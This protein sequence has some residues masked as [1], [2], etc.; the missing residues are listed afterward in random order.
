M[1]CKIELATEGSKLVM[2]G[3]RGKLDTLILWEL[4]KEKLLQDIDKVKK[5]TQYA[6]ISP[7]TCSLNFRF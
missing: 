5:S 2:W 1:L 4:K 3:A 7:Q 6:H